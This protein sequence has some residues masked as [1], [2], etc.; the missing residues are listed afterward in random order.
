MDLTSHEAALIACFAICGGQGTL[1]VDMQAAMSGRPPLATRRPA[2]CLGWRRHS[3][4]ALALSPR[5][6]QRSRVARHGAAGRP[7]AEAGAEPEPDWDAEM[8]I[9]KK[10]T[11]KPAQL[12]TLRKLE[13]QVE[14]GRVSKGGSWSS[15]GGA[16][17]ERVTRRQRRGAAGSDCAVEL[18]PMLFSC[19]FFALAL[20]CA[21]TAG[22]LL[23]GQHSH[24]RGA[25]QRR[26]RGHRAV[27]LQRGQ[28]VRWA[29]R[30]LCLP[31]RQLPG[32]AGAAP[33]RCRMLLPAANCGQ[34][35]SGLGPC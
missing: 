4:H 29:G 16:Q 13:E 27:L 8:S 32:N 2:G 15:A 31:G 34:H 30:P 11:L 28:G 20:L 5:A 26:R 12:E 24:C 33:W 1:R 17:A 35:R 23:R 21:P 6:A 3:S 18:S 14:V 22:A 19:D 9:F 25:E 10:R 7:R